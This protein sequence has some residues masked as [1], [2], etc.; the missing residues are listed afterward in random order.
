MSGPRKYVSFAGLKIVV[1]ARPSFALMWPPTM[2][3][4]PSASWM[5]PAQNRFRPYGTGV[6]M[7]VAGSQSRSEFG[8]CREAVEREDL[9]RRLERHVHGDER[10]RERV[11][12]SRR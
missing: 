6:K 4:R 9:A 12:S 7:P 3:V 2:S 1:S 11:R 5:W 8:R 10:P